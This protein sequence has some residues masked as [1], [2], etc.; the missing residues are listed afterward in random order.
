MRLDAEQVRFEGTTDTSSA[1]D[2]RSARLKAMQFTGFA[3]SDVTFVASATEDGD[4]S[5]V[6]DAAG[7]PVTFT[8]TDQTTVKVDPDDL[9]GL[10]WV[11]MVTSAD[12]TDIVVAM[13]T[14]PRT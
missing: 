9:E 5:P 14:E 1:I 3:D 6:V 2:L 11:K 10:P 7:D 8:V 12:Q 4:Y 13:L